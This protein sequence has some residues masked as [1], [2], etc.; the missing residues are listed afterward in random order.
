MTVFYPADTSASVILFYPDLLLLPNALSKQYQWIA[1]KK[2]VY[3][4]NP[5]CQ[6]W[7]GQEPKE[8]RRPS[9]SL[10]G[11]YLKGTLKMSPKE[12]KTA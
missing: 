6:F 5:V 3:P 9:V 12:L 2:K 1:F 11:I 8:S 10:Y 7:L 4:Y